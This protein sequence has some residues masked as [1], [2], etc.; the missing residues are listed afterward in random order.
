M[1]G[2]VQS[3]TSAHWP[4]GD[5]R[6]H[7]TATGSSMFTKKNT[8]R[9]GRPS[10][11]TLVRI[12]TLSSGPDENGIHVRGLWRAADSVICI[13]VVVASAVLIL[14]SSAWSASMKSPGLDILW[15]ALFTRRTALICNSNYRLRV[16]AF[17]VYSSY[18]GV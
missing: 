3:V 15:A 4:T 5:R 11:G 10:S 1:G 12:Y 13:D 16:D 9:G 8:P 17:S 7:R 18:Q 2:S 6:A 14:F